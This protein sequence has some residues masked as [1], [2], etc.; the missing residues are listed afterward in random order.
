MVFATGSGEGRIALTFTRSFAFARMRMGTAFVRVLLA[1]VLWSLCCC[2]ANASCKFAKGGP[3]NL[4]IVVPATI[5]VPR[6]AP[7]GAV[8][9]T[10]PYAYLPGTSTTS[11]S[12][13]S[14]GTQSKI[15]AQPGKGVTTYPIGNTGLSFQW[16]YNDSGTIYFFESYGTY[17]TNGGMMTPD[18]PQAFR[19]IKTGAIAAGATIPGGPW[20]ATCTAHSRV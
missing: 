16:I 13:D 7:V 3:Q 15:G 9:Y 8:I 20:P 10:S 5:T 12:N 18:L 19:L 6:D 14:I 11:C 17:T 4:N 1:F 2:A